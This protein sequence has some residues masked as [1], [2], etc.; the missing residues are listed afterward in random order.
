MLFPKGSHPFGKNFPSLQTPRIYIG[1][2]KLSTIQHVWTFSA[3]RHSTISDIQFFSQFTQ[4]QVNCFAKFTFLWPLFVTNTIKKFNIVFW[5]L[6]K[7]VRHC[8]NFVKQLG[9][10]F[11]SAILGWHYITS[12]SRQYKSICEN[13][14]RWKYICFCWATTEIST[15][16]YTSFKNGGC[17]AV[18]PLTSPACTF[19]EGTSAS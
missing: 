17:A 16:Q 8:S 9:S 18:Q 10:T 19:W 15:K 2:P 6:Q 14:F 7:Y 5:I 12:I 3:F 1:Y 13:F 11:A 4:L